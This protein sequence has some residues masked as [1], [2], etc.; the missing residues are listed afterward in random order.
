M[1]G[2]VTVASLS[3][4]KAGLGSVQ[5]LMRVVQLPDYRKDNPYQQ[6]LADALREQGI[7][8]IFPTGYRR[9]LPF[10]RGVLAIKG[11]DVLHLHWLTP[12]LKGASGV[13]KSLYAA[14]LLL[15]CLLVKARRIRLVWTVHNLISHD[16]TTPRLEIHL[17]RLMAQLADGLIVHSEGARETVAQQFRVPLEKISVIPH[18]SYAEAYGPP[19]PRLEARA[20]LGLDP[21][22][23]VFLFFGMI[24]PYKG[25]VEL[26][27]VWSAA[28]EL[29]EVALL[30]IAGDARDSAHAATIHNV[31][32]KAPNVQRHIRFIH[33]EEIPLFFGA[34]DWLVLPFAKSLTSGTAILAQAY[35]IP[36]VASN[37][38]GLQSGIAER[39]DEIFEACNRDALR[40]ALARASIRTA[41]SREDARENEGDKDHRCG[42][43]EIA[44]RHALTYAV[45][46]VTPSSAP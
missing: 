22:R 12:Y 13:V 31:A 40:G 36:L 20:R 30:I 10:S 42:W 41:A 33:D 25:V 35:G 9:G 46:P 19:V 44:R 5:E 23:P 4:T 39:A 37:V 1:H 16:T 8:T 15:D 27:E 43:A 6:L 7:E 29:H 21:Q 11:V 18:G 32:D 45:P 17:S 28:P 26:L 3:R 34:A 38:E 24:R 2:K 14:R